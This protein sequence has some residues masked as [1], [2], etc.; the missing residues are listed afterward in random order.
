MAR[1]ANQTTVSV[2]RSRGEIETILDRYGAT[3]FRYGRN[4]SKAVIEF[5]ANDRLLR[6]SLPLPE[7]NVDEFTYR[8]NRR[9]SPPMKIKATPEWAA[10]AWE[11][12]CRQRWRALAL[13]IKAKLEAVEAGISAFEQEFFANVVD[14]QTGR[15]IYE[16]IAP[17]IALSYEGCERPLLLTGPEN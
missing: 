9:Y 5:A 8:F 12:A 3:A 14:P 11:Q 13:A 2:E 17:Q 16:V 4:E 6:F 10:M 15:T 7:R 1:Y